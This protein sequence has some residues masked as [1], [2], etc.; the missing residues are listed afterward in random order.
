MP[1]RAPKHCGAAGCPVL[2]PGG[3][4][5]CRAHDVRGNTGSRGY[6][7]AHRVLSEQARAAVRPGDR[8][9]RCGKPM[10]RWQ[11]L[12]LDHN[13]ARDGYRGVVHAGCNEARQQ[14]GTG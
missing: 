13:A 4:T 10:L 5:Y 6:G 8:C 12:Q 14:P 7:R 9:W 2:V 1:P 11:R 3:V